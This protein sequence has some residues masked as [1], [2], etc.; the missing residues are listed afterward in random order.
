M[1]FD[2]HPSILAFLAVGL[3]LVILLGALICTAVNIAI[4]P[5]ILGILGV[6]NLLVLVNKLCDKR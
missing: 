5:I 6:L 1:N 2:K 3:I 4:F